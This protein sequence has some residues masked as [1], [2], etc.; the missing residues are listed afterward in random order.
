MHL[1]VLNVALAG[2]FQSEAD[3]PLEEMQP[4]SHAQTIVQCQSRHV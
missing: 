2:A 4:A 1:F 3:I